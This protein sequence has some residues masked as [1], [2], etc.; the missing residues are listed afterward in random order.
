MATLVQL[1]VPGAPCIY[2]GDEIGMAGAHDPFCRGAFPQD[3][4]AWDHGMLAFVRGLTSFRHGHTALRRGTFTPLASHG[5]TAAYRM[6]DETAGFVVALNA[7]E[8][9]ASL[10]V[11]LHERDGAT[12]QPELPVGWPWPAGDPLAIRDGSV[13]IALPARSAR[14][15]R[16][17]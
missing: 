17:R 16:I 8:E 9:A 6:A 15:L 7:G 10:I 2:Y 5:M 13:T 3:E 12:L 11:P 1:T 14:L 4:A